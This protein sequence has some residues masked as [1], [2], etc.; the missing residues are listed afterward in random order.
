M[1]LGNYTKL[2]VTH[3]Y[4]KNILTRPPAPLVPVTWIGIHIRRGDFLTFFKIDTSVDYLTT[5]MNYYR[6]KYVNAR[7]L[8]ASD[9]KE[10]V[11]KH[12]GNN[13]DVFVT[14]QGFFSGH[15]LAALTLCE[16]SIVTAGTFGWWAAWL[17]GGDVIHDLNYPVPTQNCIRE[18]Y[19][20]PWFLF[21]HNSSNQKVT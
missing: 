15:D 18:H 16:H 13:T 14:P 4:L 19:F 5:A 17:T 3:Q 8:I 9:D 1:N 2:N 21:L 12:L 11:Q 20:P 7:F 10:Y 6:R